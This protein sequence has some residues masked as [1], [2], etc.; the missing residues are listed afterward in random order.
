[1]PLHFSFSKTCISFGCFLCFLEKTTNNVW[2]C[3]I[4]QNSAVSGFVSVVLNSRDN[5][6]EN[7]IPN[8]S[9]KCWRLPANW[10]FCFGPQKPPNTSS[11]LL[12]W[13]KS[14]PS[15]SQRSW[16]CCLGEDGTEQGLSVVVWEP[17]V[18]CGR[19]QTS[20]HENHTG[21]QRPSV[22]CSPISHIEP[23]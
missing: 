21:I 3:Q 19:D 10:G 23:D 6:S 18:W 9:D 22:C 20:P 2:F 1:V 4:P 14:Y 8:Y 7:N 13:F 11:F 5:R 15:T 16:V 17:D 12:F